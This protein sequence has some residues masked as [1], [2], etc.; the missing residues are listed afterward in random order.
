MSALL[1]LL[2]LL[3]LGGCSDEPDE[4]QQP[5][6]LKVAD[7]N[8]QNFYR[9]YGDYISAVFPDARIELVSTQAASDYTVS[10]AERQK[11][12]VELVRR[13]Q[14]D[15]IVLWED[16]IYRAL[17]NEG[18]LADLSPY[19]K[20]SGVTQEQIHPG[21]LELMKQNRDGRIYGMAPGFSASQL[22]YNEDMFRKYGI[23]L[24]HDGMTW[25]EMLQLA[26]RFTAAD[27]S[28]DGPIGYYQSFME[29]ADLAYSVGDTEG[30][31]LYRLGAGKMT[32]DTPAWRHIFDTVLASYK[33]GTFRS[34]LP[35]AKVGEDGETYYDQQAM[36]S[37]D[38]FGKGQAAMTLASPG[39]YDPS[40]TKFA[41]GSVNPPV[42]EAT[43][44]RSGSFYAN[45]KLAIRSGSPEAK[46]SW[47]FIQ[48]MISDYVAKVSVAQQLEF[49]VPSNMSYSN[50]DNS[51]AALY[52][53]MPAIQPFDDI[54]S[55]G[56]S[57][58]EEMW[59]MLRQ[60]MNAALAD[61]QSVDE[62]LKRVQQQGQR[63][64][65]ESGVRAFE[66]NDGS[67]AD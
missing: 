65:D 15:L 30:M 1:M 49:G 19:M 56:R 7:T 42:D 59:G 14:P 10:A 52:R 57:F 17:A 34:M 43:R 29:P 13:E 48:F 3:G 33:N 4:A 25:A 16:E 44:T 2:V 26:Y 20:D 32:A 22:Y 60:E 12:W 61:K 46:S 24:P 31:A 18:L 36:S 53:Q 55:A 5:A 9:L 21:V 38:L 63:L 47:A 67:H 37:V 45:Q 39:Q 41:F 54:V 35:K 50:Y 66:Q 23:D 6:V 8:E 40:K 51:K 27:S 58:Y 62:M 11:R 28:P 64:I